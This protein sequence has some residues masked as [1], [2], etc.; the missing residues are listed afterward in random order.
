M[1]NRYHGNTG[2]VERVPDSPP[3]MPPLPPFS[4]SPPPNER[5]PRPNMG[6]GGRD[7]L[8]LG[9]ILN[10]FSLSNLEQEDLLLMLVIY[11]LY[12][13]SGDKELLFA[14]GALLLL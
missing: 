5:P 9:A 12:R 8:G 4:P 10:R 14:L 6:R 13:E 3:R 7:P 2:R 11:L 1:I